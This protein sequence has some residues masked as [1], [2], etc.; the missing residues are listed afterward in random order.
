MNIVI[1]KVGIALILV[2]LMVALFVMTLL[3]I[4]GVM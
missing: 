1:L 4:M 2:A 3:K